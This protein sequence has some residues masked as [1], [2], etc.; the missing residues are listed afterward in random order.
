[1]TVSN[2]RKNSQATQNERKAMTMHGTKALDTVFFHGD[3]L[4]RMSADRPTVMAAMAT[5]PMVRMM[6]LTT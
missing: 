6:S 3:A 4:L 2:V 5:F 1:M